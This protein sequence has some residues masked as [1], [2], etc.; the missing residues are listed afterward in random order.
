MNPDL[1]N[2]ISRLRYNGYHLEAMFDFSRKADLQQAGELYLEHLRQQDR[3]AADLALPISLEWMTAI[4]FR[5]ADED[6]CYYWINQGGFDIDFDVQIWPISGRIFLASPTSRFQI[7]QMED[8]TRGELLDLLS[9]LQIK[10]K[11]PT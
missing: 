5:K 3:I 1:N 2:P 8:T 11:E 9:G 10:P 6:G 4:G 7:G